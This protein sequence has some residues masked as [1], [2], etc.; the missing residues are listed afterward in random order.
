MK[1]SL[2]KSVFMHKRL[3]RL[4]VLDCKV[5]KQHSCTSS[6]VRDHCSELFSC[7]RVPK[8]VNTIT[9]LHKCY[10]LVYYRPSALIA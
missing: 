1:V 2:V 3:S 7:S 9:K 6:S 10:S 8:F 5:K 4:M